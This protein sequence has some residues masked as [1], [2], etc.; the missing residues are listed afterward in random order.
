MN[1]LLI[2]VLLQSLFLP[3][4]PA[5]ENPAAALQVPAPLKKDY[6]KAWVRFTANKTAKDDVRVAKDLEKL[7]Q[8]KKDLDP[9]LI[10]LAY[11]DLYAGRPV[12]AERKLTQVLERNPN[13]ALVLSHL[14]ELA[15]SRNDYT[16]AADLFTRLLAVDKSRTDVEAK[17]QKAVLLAADHLLRAAQDAAQEDRLAEAEGFYMQAL[18]IAPQEPTLHAQMGVLLLRERKWED[19]LTHFR[20]EVDLRGPTEEN[21]KHLAE[22][23]MNLGRTEEARTVLAGLRDFGARDAELEAQVEELED[24]GRWGKDIQYFQ[25]I[26][27]TVSLTREQL[28][29]IIIR[30]FPQVTEFQQDPQILTDIQNSWAS[31]EIRAVVGVGLID[32]F[33]NHT[34]QP[35]GQVSRADLIVSLA[36]LY[37][38]LGL[39][40]ESGGLSPVAV[41]G[42]VPDSDLYRDIQ[43][44][45]GRNMLTMDESGGFSIDVLA[46]GED[47]IHGV[48]RLLELLREKPI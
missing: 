32:A 34:F 23:L 21:Q 10:V 17:R 25:S 5:L 24:L 28:A 44:V 45:L 12:E 8:K 6:D 9:A 38:L 3:S 37:R 26:E 35:T 19:A 47:A 30:Y 16:R 14:A 31:P 22:A 40:S 7:L 15:F 48:E 33:P 13:Q 41:P 1:T 20:R 11:I 43:L 18:E 42:I 29:A 46:S 4:R 27:T 39:S 2:V 36:R